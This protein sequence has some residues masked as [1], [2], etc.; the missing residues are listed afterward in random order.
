MSSYS[1]FLVYYHSK[2]VLLFIAYFI[3]YVFK[4]EWLL[5]KVKTYATFAFFGEIIAVTLESS[6]EILVSGYFST[7]ANL[8]KQTGD[9]IGSVFAYVSLSLVIVVLPI[10][11]GIVTCKNKKEL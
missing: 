5:N 2:A 6:L 10:L 3:A 1:V 11:A 4:F 7:T 9:I 8:K